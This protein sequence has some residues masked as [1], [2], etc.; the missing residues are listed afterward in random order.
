MSYLQPTRRVSILD[1]SKAWVIFFVHPPAD[2]CSRIAY[3]LIALLGLFA[4]LNLPGEQ[5]YNGGLLM[6][7]T[8]ISYI[9]NAYFSLIGTGVAQR[10]VKRLSKRLDFSI[11]VYN[12]NLD[13]PKH[14]ARRIQQEFFSTLLLT[15]AD[16]KIP[17]GERLYFGTIPDTERISSAGPASD[18]MTVSD[19]LPPYLLAFQGSQGER[20]VENLKVSSSS[21]L[22]FRLVPTRIEGT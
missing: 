17:S 9:C 6:T 16:F 11:D 22:S 8:V 21:C 10:M 15:E 14:I 4:A 1:L 12:P 18:P 20:H 3:V 5:A 2:W 19:E 7:V 13:I